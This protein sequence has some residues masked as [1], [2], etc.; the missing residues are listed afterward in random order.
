MNR[1]QRRAADK[2]ARQT[3]NEPPNVQTRDG[4]VFDP[5]TAI[6]PIFSERSPGE[7]VAEGT[8]FYVTRFGHF[9][10]AYHVIKEF[11]ERDIPL[12]MFHMLDDGEGAIQRRVCSFCHHLATDVALGALEQPSG[13][14]FNS[15]PR[16]TTDCPQIGE[17]IIT[18]A[19]DKRTCL[20]NGTYNIKIQSWRG[21]LQEVHPKGRDSAMLP[22][23]C[24]RSNMKIRG[25]A[26]GGPVST[27]KG[28]SSR[29]TARTS[30]ARTAYLTCRGS[31]KR[32]R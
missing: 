23:P 3:A 11:V 21:V 18:M 26:S 4:K 7:H 30:K 19:Y 2:I 6:F 20:I 8:G 22:F 1:K 25:G 9:L 10:T 14:V 13:Y 24:Y 28:V 17:P 32:C 12:F 15:V 27:A 5:T 31:K 29:S 16:L